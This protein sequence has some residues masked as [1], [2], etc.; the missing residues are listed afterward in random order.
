MEGDARGEEAGDSGNPTCDRG[1]RAGMSDQA[2]VAEDAVQDLIARDKSREHLGFVVESARDGRAV[3]TLAVTEDMA[4]GLGI[5]QGGYAFAIADTALA[6]AANS[7]SYGTATTEASITFLSPAHMGDVL[8][9]EATVVLHV[10]RRTVVDVVVRAGERIVA[11]VRG[12][13]RQL[14]PSE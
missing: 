7:V 1:R 12:Q 2:S 3:V 10:G 6:M 9:A 8:T 5:A 4:N 14:R 11:L 13:G